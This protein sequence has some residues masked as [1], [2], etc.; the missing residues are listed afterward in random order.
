MRIPDEE[1]TRNMYRAAIRGGIV[2]GTKMAIFAGF[3]SGLAQWLSPA[4][5]RLTL[6][7]KTSFVVAAVTAATVITAERRMLEYEHQKH[8]NETEIA[9]KQRRDIFRRP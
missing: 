3:C 5:R 4:Y 6:P 2:G 9:K 1:D 7:I 8:F